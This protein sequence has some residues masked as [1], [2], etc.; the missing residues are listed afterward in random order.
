MS[1]KMVVIP[2]DKYEKLKKNVHTVVDLPNTLENK[3]PQDGVKELSEN[4]PIQ[5]NDSNIEKTLSSGDD[6]L[7]SKEDIVEY[8]PKMYQHRCRLILFHMNNNGMRWDSFGRLLL[9][10]E[11]VLNTHVV[12]LI[13]DVISN[14]KKTPISPSATHF[15]QLLKATHCPHSILNKSKS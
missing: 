11:C 13:R 8:M 1:L 9:N 7:L 15:C 4:P 2:L 3:P 12:D 10:D 5:R 6:N 14:Y